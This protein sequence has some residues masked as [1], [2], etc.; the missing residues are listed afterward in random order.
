MYSSNTRN[1]NVKLKDKIPSTSHCRHSAS[2]GTR[3]FQC[4]Y[5]LYI[6]CINDVLVSVQVFH[7]YIYVKSYWRQT[8]VHDEK[9]HVRI[10]S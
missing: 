1:E 5:V 10:Q 7:V 9:F 2:T 3:C 6:P 8:K 4:I